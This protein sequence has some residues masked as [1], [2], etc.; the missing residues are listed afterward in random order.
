MLLGWHVDSNIAS[1]LR[2][3]YG[4]VG[5]LSDRVYGYHCGHTRQIT[6]AHSHSRTENDW[7]VFV[8]GVERPDV[9]EQAH[10]WG[11]ASDDTEEIRFGKD[12]SVVYI[13][14]LKE[15]IGER[16]LVPLVVKYRGD[17]YNKT[18]YDPRQL[19]PFLADLFISSDKGT[20]VARF[21][22]RTDTLGPIC[23]IVET[24]WF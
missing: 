19:L 14:A 8:D 15:Q 11:C 6:P 2:L 24:A 12:G 3:V 20:N 17:S 7:R 13:S 18:A 16:L 1:R 9:P 23:R 5:D 4:S 22:A 10:S 21:G